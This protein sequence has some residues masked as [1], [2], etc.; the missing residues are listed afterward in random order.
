MNP[1]VIYLEKFLSF[2]GL[3]LMAMFEKELER[4]EKRRQE[5]ASAQKLLGLPATTYPDL[6]KA[7]EDAKA[8]KQVY[9]IYAQLKVSV[10]LSLQGHTC[11]CTDTQQRWGTQEEAALPPG[12]CQL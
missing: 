4:L 2:P 8:L 5:L 7:Q 11:S 6:I 9:D 12:C 3:E 10:T 1:V